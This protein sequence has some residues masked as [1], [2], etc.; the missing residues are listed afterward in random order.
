MTEPE[1]PE[2]R[3]EPT[4]AEL[5]EWSDALLAEIDEVLSSD[6]WAILDWP[7]DGRLYRMYDA[8]ALRHVS[9]LLLEIEVV[10]QVGLELSVRVLAR[11]HVEAFLYALYI[12]FGGHDAVM[13]VAQDT[14]AALEST[15]NDFDSYNTWLKKEKRRLTKRRDKIRKNNAANALWNTEYPD[16]PARPIMTE[17]YIPQLSTTPVDLT[18]AI[19]E[20]GTVAAKSLSVKEVVDA[21]TEW[22][23]IKGFGRE[24]FAPMYHIYRVISGASLHPTLNVYDSYFQ[25][26]G[27]VR[28]AT[29]PIGPSMIL[30]TRITALYSTA[31]LAG[32]VLGDAGS[33]TP[34]ATFLR[35]RLEPDPSGGRGWA[36]GS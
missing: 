1:S 36:P 7:T 31:F 12:H 4:D 13:R 25:A 14:R 3:T 30:A 18:G 15:Q 34:V 29:V 19:A 9:A 24:S 28:T 35:N 33:P 20:F 17:P 22:A 27:F 16:K 2:P 11:T 10:G 21:L 8:A 23:P 6:R 26:G 5:R 32:W